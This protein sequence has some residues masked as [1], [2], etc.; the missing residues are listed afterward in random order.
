VIQSNIA[1]PLT[2]FFLLSYGIAWL[3]WLPLVLSKRGLGWLPLEGRMEWVV[4]ASFAPTI[5]AF[6]THRWFEKNWRAID[7]LQG[8]RRA[9]IGTLLGPN[10]A[11]VGI[12]VIPSLILS[13]TP[14]ANLKWETFSYYPVISLHWG[15]LLGGPLGEEPGWRG[16][17][18]PKLQASFKPIWAAA[19]LGVIWTFW[20]LPLFLV[21][22]W[23]SSPL[24]IYVIIIESLS[25]LSAFSFNVSGGS[26]LVAVIAHSAGNS[27]SRLLNGV[28]KGAETR[29]NLSGD[30]IIA[31]T[32]LALALIV[33]ISTRG[34]LSA[35]RVN[36]PS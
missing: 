21:N 35:A 23:T 18:L 20:H 3:L 8:W 2:A 19:I 7:F 12:V 34:R 22:G 10:L 30:L 9:W 14:A 26:V 1:R 4:P 29:D 24:W 25:V 11:A 5:A 16:Y 6:L 13:K 32:L 17:A 33:A 15:S 31:L 36:P 27:C 28:L